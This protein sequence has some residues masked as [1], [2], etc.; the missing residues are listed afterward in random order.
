MAVATMQLSSP[1]TVTGDEQAAL[2]TKA[3]IAPK[4]L[5]FLVFASFA[6]YKAAASLKAEESRSWDG[7]MIERARLNNEL[8]ESKREGLFRVF[9]LASADVT[10]ACDYFVCESN[11]LRFHHIDVTYSYSVASPPADTQTDRHAFPSRHSALR[12]GCSTYVLITSKAC[13]AWR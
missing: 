2:A 11:G 12:I 5:V 6:N 3:L 8:R 7:G 9:E 10:A 4:P 1:R 13:R